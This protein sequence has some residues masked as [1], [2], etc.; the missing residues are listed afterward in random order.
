MTFWNTLKDSP[1]QR[2]D[3]APHKY[4]PSLS[5]KLSTEN[6]WME[7][8]LH[9]RNRLM[10]VKSKGEKKHVKSPY[11]ISFKRKNRV[12][13]RQS[14]QLPILSEYLKV[15]RREAM[16]SI[17]IQSL[18]RRYQAILMAKRFRGQKLA[19][20]VIQAF[21]R[22]FTKK[23]WY[24]KWKAD[25]IYYATRC[26]SRR[27]QI[28]ISKKWEMQ[29]LIEWN[30]IT[31]IQAVIRTFLAKCELVVL[32]R[33]KCATAIQA[34]WRGWI[35]RE[36]ASK[37]LL[38]VMATKIQCKMRRYRAER[39]VVQLGIESN[40]SSL[41]IQKCWRGF[42]A[43][44]FRNEILFDR[45]KENCRRQIMVWTTEIEYYKKSLENLLM[46]EEE[47]KKLD[48]LAEIERRI[49]ESSLALKTSERNIEELMR[50]KSQVTPEM[51]SQGWE[52]EIIKGI[53]DERQMI[54]DLKLELLLNLGF[55]YEKQKRQQHKLRD[56][57][58]FL[59]KKVIELQELRQRL[60]NS[61]HREEKELI[62]RTEMKTKRM[63]IADEKRKWR[64]EHRH[65]NGKP[66][67]VSGTENISSR[68]ESFA[69]CSGNINIIQHACPKIDIIDRIK[70]QSHLNELNMLN[71]AFLDPISR[72]N[73][74]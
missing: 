48:Q 58:S 56:S 67:R 50:S 43:R 62:K 45:H 12:A 73:N 66:M 44:K 74:S 17:V 5:S 38:D 35:G 52:D 13:V 37:V 29:C 40:V 6:L 59:E 60:V 47:N 23:K 25:V 34:F 3:D 21:V 1:N 11:Q 57:K 72:I 61:V 51:V 16:A 22:T 39:S 53:K 54:T 15:S 64:V 4:Y 24:A 70:L 33:S 26:Q 19:V 63:A 27:R 8:C 31:K 55:H 28:V 71:Q 9:E 18:W 20:I 32:V 30:S 46:V 49:D 36:V 2:R 68:K 10:K 65:P 14:I 69:F 41:T 7:G 42:I